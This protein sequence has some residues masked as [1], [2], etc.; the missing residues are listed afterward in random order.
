MFILINSRLS[1]SQTPRN[2]PKYFEISTGRH[3]R[4]AELN[5]RL[6]NLIPEIR[7]ILKIL[8]KRGEIAPKQFLLFSTIFCHLL[9]DFHVK[10]RV[11]VFSSSFQLFET[12]GRDNES[13]Y[14]CN[15]QRYLCKVL[16]KCTT[17][18]LI[19]LK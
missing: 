7:D 5:E 14:N 16:S 9:L 4:F 11:Q 18:L 8:W 6:C 10:K 1:L 17:T 13:T 3:I 12:I 15:T 19:Y 2:Y